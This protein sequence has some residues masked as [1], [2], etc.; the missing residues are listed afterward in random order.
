MSLYT[1]SETAVALASVDPP[2]SDAIF[3]LRPGAV[4]P[5][6]VPVFDDTLAAVIGYREQPTT[7]VYRLYDLAGTLI[8]MEERGLESPLLDPLDLLFFGGGIIRAI[9]KGVVKGTARTAPKVAA[10]G[11]A[12]ISSGVLAGAIVGAM[13]A[14]FKGLSVRNLQFTLATAGR[15]ATKGRYVPLHILHLGIKYGKRVPDPQGVKGAF[16][17]TSKMLRNGTEY[18]LEIVVRESDWTILHFLYK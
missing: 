5:K 13:R 11:A 12:R 15:M 7:G 14:S 6:A 1:G 2:E 18:T 10:L 3:E 17:Y 8:G 9:G 4:P 16:L